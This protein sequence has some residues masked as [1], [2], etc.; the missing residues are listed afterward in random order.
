MAIC[1]PGSEFVLIESRALRIKWLRDIIAALRLPNVT[2]AAGDAVKIGAVEAGC[3]S[4]R[5]F[6]PL[7]RFIAISARFSTD[8]TH[9]VLPKGRSAAQEVAMLPPALQRMFHVKQSITDPEA[10]IVIGFGKVGSEL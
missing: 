10:G 6:A 2:L 5:A 7:N 1:D 9:W 8:T 4:G 3:I